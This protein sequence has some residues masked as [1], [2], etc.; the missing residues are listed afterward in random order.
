MSQSVKRTISILAIIVASVAAGV[1]LTADFGWMKKS[2]AQQVTTTPDGSVA[3]MTVPSFADL[4]DRVMPAVVS[5]TSKEI[6][7]GQS[8]QGINPFDFFFPDHPRI[9]NNQDNEREQISGGSGF[10]ISP[11][12]YILTNN[13]VIEGASSIEVRIGKEDTTV[14]AKIIGR[15]PATDIA[16]IKVDVGHPLPTVKLGDS[17]TTRV[18]DW[19]IAIGNPLEM[20]N[21]LT[22]GVISAKGRSLGISEATASFENFLQ[23]DAAINFGNSGGPLLNIKGEVIGINTAIRAMAQNIGFAIPIDI[24]K[25]VYPQLKASGK[26]TRGY[27]G[28]N[29]TEIDEKYQKA[30]NLPNMNGVLVQNVEASGPAAKAGIQPGDVI[31][32]VDTRQ[33]KSSRDLIDY[34]SDLGPGK[35]ISITLIRNG[36]TEHVTATTGERPPVGQET[37]QEGGEENPARNRIGLTVQQI[38]PGLRQMYGLPSSANGV[39]ITDVKSVSPAAE[40]GL[41]QGDVITSAAG[42]TIN[43]PQELKRIVDRMKS[44]E[45]LR[46]YVSR[47]GRNGQSQ[48]FFVPVQIP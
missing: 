30:F 42:E 3:M 10:I 2:A 36:K 1:I 5:I 9:P 32:Q 22:V 21:T 19:A 38:T 29:I 35:R 41:S 26:V 47:F 8:G 28:I 27:L 43:T 39:I 11:D 15:D 37:N 13:H 33:I 12:G 4:A 6:V 24:A 17:N 7:H 46:L 48:S 31:I 18:G 40:A 20:E 45:Y 44:G 23:T 25:K 16:L 34:V 14:P